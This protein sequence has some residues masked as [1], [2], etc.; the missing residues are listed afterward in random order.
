M[1][2]IGYLN[3]EKTSD[4]YRVG[5]GTFGYLY[6]GIGSGL[7][8]I[9]SN[10]HIEIPHYISVDDKMYPVVE[11]SAYCFRQITEIKSVVLPHTLKVISTDAFWGTSIK[12]LLIPSSVKELKYYTFST[13]RSLESITFE[14]GIN[15]TNVMPYLFFS[16]TSLKTIYYWGL[17][18]L[19]SIDYPFRLC[20]NLSSIYVLY[21]YPS[22][23]TFGGHAVIRSFLLSPV[24]KPCK[25]LK[26][27]NN[28]FLIERHDFL[29]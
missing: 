17:T 15:L 2:T 10:G 6:N 19:S 16:C 21:N 27:R 4:G 13:M 1:I 28:R 24:C 3:Y 29:D 25:T 20:S 11:L 23:G 14:Y 26:I 9:P 7:A 12:D 18:D 22:N 5:N 8:K